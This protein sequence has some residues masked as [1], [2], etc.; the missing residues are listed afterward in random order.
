MT[1]GMLAG[2]AHADPHLAAGPNLENPDAFY[3]P[4]HPLNVPTNC[5]P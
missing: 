3:D 2:V 5:A 1:V 4:N